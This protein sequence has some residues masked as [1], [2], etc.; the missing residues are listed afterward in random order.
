MHIHPKVFILAA[1]GEY[2]SLVGGFVCRASC[3]AWVFLGCSFL[4]AVTVRTLLGAHRSDVPLCLGSNCCLRNGH[5]PGV[6]VSG[7]LGA[8]WCVGC[9]ATAVSRCDKHSAGALA[10]EQAMCSLFFLLRASRGSMA[11]QLNGVLSMQVWMR[12]PQCASRT[13]GDH[14]LHIATENKENGHPW[15]RGTF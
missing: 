14:M 11:L 10:P 6:D 7:R 1:S 2:Q 12:H 15:I 4:L 13:H 8:S 9:Y 5:F 3:V